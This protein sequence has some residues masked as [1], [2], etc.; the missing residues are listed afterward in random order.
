LLALAV[1]FGVLGFESVGN[2]LEK[3]QSEDDVLILRRIH[4]VAQRVCCRPKLGFE[5]EIGA[6]G[7]LFLVG[8]LLRFFRHRSPSHLILT[9]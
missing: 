1:E 2:V 8:S 4:I 6:I 3:N 7:I 5:A 9:Q